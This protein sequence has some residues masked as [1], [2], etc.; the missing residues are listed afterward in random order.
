MTSD[1]GPIYTEGKSYRARAEARQR[2]YRA[3]SGVAHG[4]YGHFLAQE[5]AEAGRNF[6]LPES[7]EA[8]RTRQQTG[9]GVAPRTFEN[10][11]SSQAMAFNLFTPLGTRLDLA[12]QVLRPFVAGLAA[13]RSIELEHTP[14]G[15]VFNDQTGR[16]GVDCDLLIEGTNAEGDSLVLVIE[17][18]FVEPEFSTCGFTKSGRAEKGQEVCPDD[19]P[20]RLDRTACLYSR[21]KGYA[22]WQ[23]SDE[24]ALL[25]DG[26]LSNA[27]CPFAGA[28]WQLWVNLALAHE[29]A[30]RRGAKD[31]R[32]A[33][34]AS[35]NN[36]A[37][38]AG[39]NV[40]DGFRAL[41]RRPEAVLFLDLDALLAR[42]EEVVPADLAAWAKTLSARYRGI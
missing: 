30:K 42:V 11:L 15:D 8:A 17:T 1:L 33:V 35:A 25:A 37:L 26:A 34:C 16:G 6:I 27:G 13:V 18:K 7:F 21:N 39:G 10:M 20:V 24:H 3:S 23:R 22:Y 19:V 28:N 14:S 12:A 5:A 29:E 36:D 32:F 2:H 40:L 41:L 38:L 4:S 31:V 9:K